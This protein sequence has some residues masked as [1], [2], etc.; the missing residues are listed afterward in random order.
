MLSDNV[1]CTTLTIEMTGKRTAVHFYAG[2]LVI[3]VHKFSRIQVAYSGHVL[4]AL[5]LYTHNF[6]RRRKECSL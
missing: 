4:H 1:L 6:N 2:K 3:T 5:Y